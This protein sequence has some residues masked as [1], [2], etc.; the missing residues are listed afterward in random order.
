MITHSL[1]VASLQMIS[2]PVVAENLSTAARLI[3]QAAAQGARLALLPEYFCLMGHADTDKLTIQ[4]TFGSGPIQA[5]LSQQATTHGISIIAGT[6]PIAS[7]VQGR[8]YN[9]T[10]VYNPQGQCT[11]RYDKI[12]LFCFDNGSEAYNEARVLLPGKTP[13]LA[14]IE[15][16]KVAL[17]ICYDL[18]FPELYRTLGQ[19]AP[20]DLIVMP[21]AFTYTTGLAH[22]EMLIRA[23]AVENQCYVLACGQGGLHPNGRRTYGHSMLVD[24]WGKVCNVLQ[25]GE[26]IVLGTL[27]PAKL[28]EIRTNLPALTHRVL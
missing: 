21:A 25:E 7:G 27:D 12:H 1:K 11:A 26:G 19:Q 23:R 5:F 16:A 4:E 24:P 14:D 9:T 3:E 20:I 10:L 13:V 8:V 6:L 15:G 28:K 18:R 22:W 17:S 2:T